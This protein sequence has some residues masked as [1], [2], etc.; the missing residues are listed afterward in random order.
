LGEINLFGQVWRVAN[1]A[2]SFEFMRKIKI[3]IEYDGRAYCGWQVQLNGVAIQEKI[4]KALEKILKNKTTVIASG[5]TDA[6]VHAEAQVAHFRTESKMTPFQLLKA[7]NSI[8]P[9]DISIKD[10]CDVSPNFHSIASAKKKIYRYSI[11]NRD[12]P[13]ALNFGRVWYM[14]RLLNVEAMKTA[15]K[16]LEGEHDFT[17]FR[18]SG[19][20]ANSPVKR[21][22]KIWFETQDG[23]INIFFEGGGFLKYMVRNIM[24]TLVLVGKNRMEPE[25]VEKLLKAK[26]RKIAGPTAP[27]QGLCLVSVEYYDGL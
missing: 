25:D 6:G 2:S 10:V 19:C 27:P 26:N 15:A 11:L 8:L 13:S 3:I 22:F 9:S 18:A 1:G 21:I 5:R 24:G 16:C 4:Q 12:F 17:S 14:E 23:L 20:G 7:L